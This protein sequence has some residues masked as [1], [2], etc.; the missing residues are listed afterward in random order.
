MQEF[1]T[2]TMLA[3]ELGV[4][5]GIIHKRIKQGKVQVITVV[6]D[7]SVRYLIP[8]DQIN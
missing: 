1:L 8:R 3:K 6:L 7:K 5:R 4:S 2:P